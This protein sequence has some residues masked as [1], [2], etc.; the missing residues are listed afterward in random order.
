MP[1]ITHTYA[2]GT[3]LL[4]HTL[5]HMGH[6]FYYT[7]LCIWDMPSITH[8][9]AYGICLL[10]HTLMH[11]GHAFYY[12]HL[13]IWDM[14]SITHTCAYGTCHHSC[15][16]SLLNIPMHIGNALSHASARPHESNPKIFK[17]WPRRNAFSKL[18][19]RQYKPFLP[20]RFL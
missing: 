4:L 9:D 10:L 18:E 7:H 2:Y 3:C 6:A 12:T 13:C 17:G 5:M 15:I 11:M 1:S 20:D 14:P 16:P 19:H 8:T